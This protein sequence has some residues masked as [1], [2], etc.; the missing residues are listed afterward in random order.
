MSQAG[1]SGQNQGAPPPPP[2][3]QGDPATP[4]P[5]RT[6]LYEISEAWIRA[7]RIL[8]NFDPTGTVTQED[9]NSIR[10]MG[11]F[12]ASLRPVTTN[13][14]SVTTTLDH[15]TILNDT[16]QERD[17]YASMNHHLTERNR[18][19]QTH[20]QVDNLTRALGLLDGTRAAAPAATTTPRHPKIPDA[21]MF[22]GKRESL[23]DWLTAIKLKTTSPEFTT[24]TEKMTYTYLR[25]EGT[26]MTQMRPFLNDE[27][28]WKF[29]TFAAFLKQINDAFGDPDAAATAE[30]ALLKLRQNN[31]DFA[32]YY[33]EFASLAADAT[34]DD[35]SKLSILKRGLSRELLTALAFHVPQPKNLTDFVTLCQELDNSVRALNLDLAARGNNS[36]TRTTTH[37]SSGSSPNATT[38]TTTTT[39]TAAP[40]TASGAHSGPM[41]TS[42]G[43]TT[44]RRPAGKRG[45]LTNE[46]KAD[47]AA[48]GTCFYCDDPGHSVAN[49]PR[50][51]QSRAPPVKLNAL[52]HHCSG[53]CPAP[54]SDSGKGHTQA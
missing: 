31:R 10:Q 47:R 51:P 5:E 23:R 40:S 25:L 34:W 24:D 50:K 9:I 42:A 19:L 16:V 48:R 7:V 30:R 44:F 39:T 12:F 46:Q 20:W 52:E 2:P 14:V 41:D 53:A 11:N 29:D 8:A 22:A 17:N 28:A 21:P 36:T 1:P 4:T 49:C 33:S 45:A 54:D 13:Y 26:A 35:P 27:G 37:R 32:T 43:A 38:S 6:D 3:P 15:E 18:T